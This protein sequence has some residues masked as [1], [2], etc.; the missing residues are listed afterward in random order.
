MCLAFCRFADRLIQA[1]RTVEAAASV[2]GS[3]GVN[4]FE[5]DAYPRVRKG[6]E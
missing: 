2:P 5:P 3:P 4:N 6:P 1:N